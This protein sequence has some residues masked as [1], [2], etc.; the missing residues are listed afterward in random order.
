MGILIIVLLMASCA[1]VPPNADIL[2][3]KNMDLTVNGYP[4]NGIAVLSPQHSYTIRAKFDDSIEKIKLTTCH[5]YYVKTNVGKKFEYTYRKSDGVENNGVCV[6]ELAAF[7]EKKNE[8]RWATLEF[9][10]DSDVIAP[11]KL[12]CNG[13]IQQTKGVS[14]CQSQIGLRQAIEFNKKTDSYTQDECDKPYTYD[15]KKF[16]IDL[17]QGACIYLFDNED[18]YHRLRTYGYHDEL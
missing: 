16:Y 9:R 11:A 6:M 14:I 5:R 4:I 12:L 3:K 7:D 2:Y 18:G 13:V 1:T 15:N 8:N 10:N 17:T